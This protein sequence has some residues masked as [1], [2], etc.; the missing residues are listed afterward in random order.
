MWLGWVY[1]FFLLFLVL[2]GKKRE[3]EK[4]KKKDKRGW[5]SPRLLIAWFRLHT[6]WAMGLWL[7]MGNI[8]FIPFVLFGSSNNNWL[9]LTHIPCSLP[10]GAHFSTTFVGRL[11]RPAKDKT[12][13]LHFSKANGDDFPNPITPDN[14]SLP[15]FSAGGSRNSCQWCETKP[16]MPQL[17]QIDVIEP[18]RREAALRKPLIRNG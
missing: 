12:S 15:I 13:P 11:L 3:R 5:M 2:S 8:T 7:S 16:Q 14:Y 18:N 17:C 6:M 4:N 10:A 9:R 1:V